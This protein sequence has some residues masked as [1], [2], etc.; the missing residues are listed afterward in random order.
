MF[1]HVSLY[2]CLYAH[3]TVQTCARA[4]THM[5]Q[6]GTTHDERHK[7]R[8]FICFSREFIQ[9]YA[10]EL[11]FYIHIFLAIWAA[12]IVLKVIR[13]SYKEQALY[14]LNSDDLITFKLTS[15]QMARSSKK[16]EK[17]QAINKEKLKKVTVEVVDSS[18][19]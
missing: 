1:S 9:F 13:I 12:D 2:Y 14:A 6:N 11:Y 15:K 7:K 8:T 18:Y 3:M 4:H 16:C 5:L 19:S 10:S 17:N